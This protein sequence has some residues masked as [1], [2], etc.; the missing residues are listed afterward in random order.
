MV[1]ETLT[2]PQK[3]VKPRSYFIVFEKDTGKILRINNSVVDINNSA[4]IQMETENP[5]CKK[6]VNGKASLKK[7]GIIWDIVN[8]KW[9]IDLR[10]TTL[11]IESKHNKL[12]PFIK[13]L[14]PTTSEIFVNVFY[15]D[16]R[17]V[18]EA[19]KNNIS[20]IKNLSDI[21]EISTTEVNLLDIFVTK[22]NDPD[23]LINI[24]NI[25]PLTLFKEGTQTVYLKDSINNQVD[26]ENISLY[27]KSVFNNYGWSLQSRNS[28]RGTITNRI[29]QQSNVEDKNNININVVDNVMHI[30]SK[31]TESEVYYFEGRNKLRIV[32]CDSNVD[33]LVGAFEVSVDQLLHDTSK[34]DINFK[35]PEDP[36]LLYKNNYLAVSTD[37]EINE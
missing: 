35:W 21:T 25:N 5:I 33:N 1:T 16:R 6:L 37:G 14:D 27:A 7:Y 30:K 24:I 29:L 26:W 8:G 12:T 15:D 13:N 10:S 20:S 19:N 34:L 28:T 17:I 36:I 3:N 22:K 4:H 18:V 9:D 2:K 23:Y 11:I 31:I 32:V